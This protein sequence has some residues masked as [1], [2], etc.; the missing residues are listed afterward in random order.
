[1]YVFQGMGPSH[2]CV[3]HF[4][5]WCSESH[6][7][8]F[9]PVGKGVAAGL[10]TQQ[11]ALSVSAL[12]LSHRCSCLTKQ[13]SDCCVPYTVQQ[14]SGRTGAWS[15]HL[16]SGQLCAVHT[17]KG[18]VPALYMLSFPLLACFVCFVLPVNVSMVPSLRLHSH[19]LHFMFSDSVF[20]LNLHFGLSRGGGKGGAWQASHRAVSGLQYSAV[21]SLLFIV[22]L[23]GL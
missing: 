16:A 2:P 6:R 9:V 18:K 1:M 11:L 21:T 14:P 7:S 3:C 22:L 19:V 5:T 12:R 4:C 8:N 13:A 17:R 10:A 15:S 23:Q 20:S